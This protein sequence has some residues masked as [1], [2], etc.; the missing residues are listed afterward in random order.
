MGAL[1]RLYRLWP[2]LLIL[3]LLAAV[4]Y[5]IVTFR[6]TPERAKEVLIKVFLVITGVLCGIC[7]LISGYAWLD[8]NEPV[9]D[10]ALSC[11]VLAAILLG[12]TLLCRWRFL[13]N[14]PNYRWKPMKAKVV[15]RW[16]P[17][18]H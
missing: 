2:V 1:V 7:A 12:I 15:H 3:A 14:H 8:G 4:I 18:K 11:L 16:P 17:W 10:L 5:L 6:H 13:K 9:L